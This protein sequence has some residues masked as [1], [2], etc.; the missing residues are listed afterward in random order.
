MSDLII[1]SQIQ[2]PLVRS[3]LTASWDEKSFTHHTSDNIPPHSNSRHTVLPLE[4]RG[5]GGKSDFG[6][7]LTFKIPKK[8]FLTNMFL[9]YETHWKG[10]DGEEQIKSSHWGS[11]GIGMLEKVVLR[12]H[13]LELETIYAESM[14]EYLHSLEDELAWAFRQFIE[15]KDIGGV[16]GGGS[17]HVDALLFN[18]TF[19]TPL[20]FSITHALSSL[21]A[22]HRVED[23]FLEVHLFKRGTNGITLFNTSNFPAPFSEEE[24]NYNIVSLHCDFINYQQSV[25]DSIWN[26]QIPNAKNTFM[27]KDETMTV[28]PRHIYTSEFNTDPGESGHVEYVHRMQLT[29]KDDVYEFIVYH[30]IARE[31]GSQDVDRRFLNRSFGMSK[32]QLFSNTVLLGEGGSSMESEF[33]S[34]KLLKNVNSEYNITPYTVEQSGAVYFDGIATC[35]YRL[36]FSMNS[37]PMKYGGAVNARN[38]PLTLVMKTPNIGVVDQFINTF[39][40]A[41]NHRLISI[42][43]EGLFFDPS[44]V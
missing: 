38:M 7:V 25:E 41:R 35:F 10:I 11:L 33:T 31:V 39:V 29:A 12:T 3:L 16:G 13:R 18:T 28:S 37:D 6:D 43:E 23:L 40:I 2:S 30:G 8:G 15:P 36:N 24:G 21:I 19:N 9:K 4:A 14:W 20:F 32:M 22:T 1:N 17:T 27:W 42:D 34:K 5:A 44:L 26:A